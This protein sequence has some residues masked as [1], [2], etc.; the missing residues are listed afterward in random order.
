MWKT[1]IRS[2]RDTFNFINTSSPL[3]RL[4]FYSEGGQY[5]AYFEPVL[6]ELED[7]FALDIYYLTSDPDDLLLSNS[8]SKIKPYFIGKG[9]AR[10]FLLNS[11]KAGIVVM[12][13]PDINTFHIKRSK[14]CQHY[15]YLHHSMV[16]THMV[17]RKRAFDHFDSILCVGPHHTGF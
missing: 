2:W 11:L 14:F 13:M 8:S 17:Y 16:S 1:F 5:L 10:T 12:T 15:C 9:S 3:A 4:V 7:K 6:K